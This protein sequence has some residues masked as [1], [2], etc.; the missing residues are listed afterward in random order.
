MREFKLPSLGS[1][2][3]EGKLVEWR[4]K[5]GD[6]VKSGDVVA[7]VETS[8][9]AINVD[10]WM[11]GTISELKVR[12]GEMIP[13]GTVMATLEGDEPAGTA[14]A[15]D[16]VPAAKTASPSE[17][18]HPSAAGEA[19]RASPAAR[20]RAQALGVDW[21]KLR[22]TGPH[23][24]VSLEDVERA[25]GREVAAA[26]PPAPEPPP[27]GRARDMRR[28]IAA[29]MSR[30]KREIPH[31]YLWRDIPLAKASAW[32]EKT[33]E[34]RPVSTRLLMA[35]LLLKAA[36]AAARRF[37]AMN[38]FFQ[39]DAFHPSEAVHLGVAISLR[40]GGLLAP[41]LLDADKMPLD[42]L[43]A[44]LSDLVARVRAGNLK[45]SELT[46]PTLTVT[47]VGDQG[48]GAVLG[49]IHPP[50]VAMI[51]FGRVSARAWAENGELTAQPIVTASLAA[52]HRVSDGHEGGRFLA[53]IHDLLQ[54]PEAL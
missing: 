29:T 51:G 46:A 19:P 21:T 31:Y 28:V 22:G 5:P 26:T 43:M 3:D 47:N 18:P 54:T 13:V 14:A 48:A 41:A 16:Q 27:A 20:K 53:A 38:G 40:G 6:R 25:A 39:D 35:A 11:E 23:G 12:P 4:V 52:D 49:V 32:L 1:D 33:N 24:A 36:A 15:A 9:A 37:P 2:M 42:A 30:S 34:V 44:G 45:M 8:K 10:I 50:Q 7:V 17:P